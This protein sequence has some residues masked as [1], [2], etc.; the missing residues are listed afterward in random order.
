V[1]AFHAA[2]RAF[3][4]PKLFLGEPFD[5]TAFNALPAFGAGMPVD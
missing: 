5:P 4:Y 3:Y 2:L 1:R